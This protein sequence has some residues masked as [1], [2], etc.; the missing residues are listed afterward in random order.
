MYVVKEEYK[1]KGVV[2]TVR[3]N[4]DDHTSIELDFASPAEIE[5]LA[6]IGHFTVEESGAKKK[7]EKMPDK[8]VE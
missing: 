8:I 6:G 5:M 3:R 4:Q 2:V 1:N 7:P